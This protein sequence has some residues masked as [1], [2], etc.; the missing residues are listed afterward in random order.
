MCKG[1]LDKALK[2]KRAKGDAIPELVSVANFK[3]YL[4]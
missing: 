1:D 2:Q 3:H 4:N